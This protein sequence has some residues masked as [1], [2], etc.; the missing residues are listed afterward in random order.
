MV[1]TRN[2]FIYSFYFI[3]SPIREEECQ[4]LVVVTEAAFIRASVRRETL[5]L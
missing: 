2:L 5:Y 3:L 4:T 1:Q